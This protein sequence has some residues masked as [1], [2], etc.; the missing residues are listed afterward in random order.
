MGLTVHDARA[1]SRNT[2]RPSPASGV[3]RAKGLLLPALRGVSNVTP[4]MM[5]RCS[6]A[7]GMCTIP[8][9]PATP[10]KKTHKPTQTHTC[11]HLHPRPHH[12]W[13]RA[14]LAGNR[15]C[16]TPTFTRTSGAALSVLVDHRSHLHP[17]LC[18]VILH[19]TPQGRATSSSQTRLSSPPLPS[20]SRNR[21][22]RPTPLGQRASGRERG[23]RRQ[24]GSLE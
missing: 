7:A 24:G 17:R 21:A 6:A 14:T 5:R 18:R 22:S 23:I 2:T 15:A 19:F 9:H 8:A 16:F 12:P 11:T 4:G 20:S 3:L 10:N 13:K 1:R